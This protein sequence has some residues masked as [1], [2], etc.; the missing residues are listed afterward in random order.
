MKSKHDGWTPE[1]QVEEQVETQEQ[2]TPGLEAARPDAESVPCSAG[3]A[4]LEAA[5][6]DKAEAW[7]K[8][9]QERIDEPEA[10]ALYEDMMALKRVIDIMRSRGATAKL[11]ERPDGAPELEPACEAASMQRLA[12][13]STDK[14]GAPDA[15]SAGSGGAGGDSKTNTPI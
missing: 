3:V 14:S 15:A 10:L 8:Y 2:I 11:I 13:R 7:R 6:R 9:S 5:L 1:E 4:P 12:R